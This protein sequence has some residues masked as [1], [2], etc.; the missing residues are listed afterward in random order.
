MKGEMCLWIDKMRSASASYTR[1]KRGA[2]PDWHSLLIFVLVP[3]TRLRIDW[4][5]RIFIWNK[6]GLWVESMSQWLFGMLIA[7]IPNSSLHTNWVILS[8]AISYVERRGKIPFVLPALVGRTEL[9]AFDRTLQWPVFSRVSLRSRLLTSRNC[10]YWV[11]LGKFLWDHN[12]AW[13]PGHLACMI[14][15]GV[16]VKVPFM[17]YLRSIDE[18]VTRS[19]PARGIYLLSNSWS[20]YR[21][22]DV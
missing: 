19:A 21:P 1:M 2:K 18:I 16:T 5:D 11:E 10:R 17:R 15:P 22:S 9:N 14:D 6:I 20:S 13:I 12:N 4:S 3:G 7:L 8:R